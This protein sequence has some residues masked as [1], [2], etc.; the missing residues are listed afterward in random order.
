MIHLQNKI[1]FNFDRLRLDIGRQVANDPYF[2]CLDMDA[3]Q[4]HF[5]FLQAESMQLE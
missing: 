3:L 4:S 2:W 5:N 1:L